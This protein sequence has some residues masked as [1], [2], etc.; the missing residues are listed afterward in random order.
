M[1]RFND[2][3]YYPG[4]KSVENCLASANPKYSRMIRIMNTLNMIDE[5]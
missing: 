4:Q 3:G 2:V 5:E 1:E